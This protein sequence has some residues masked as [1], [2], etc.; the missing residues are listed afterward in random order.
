MKN[1]DKYFLFWCN[2]CVC[3][4][5]LN[6]L[7]HRKRERERERDDANVLLMIVD[8]D[9]ACIGRGMEAVSILLSPA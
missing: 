5:I 4:D 7:K 3:K 1:Q 8:L 9:G 2:A 6:L